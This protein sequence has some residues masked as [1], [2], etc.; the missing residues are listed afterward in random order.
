ML[1]LLLLDPAED[2]VIFWCQQL[3]QQ[4]RVLLLLLAARNSCSCR[5]WWMPLTLLLSLVTGEPVPSLWSLL[6][7]GNTS[8]D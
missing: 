8:G 2:D 1:L 3:E 6:T 5:A 4:S 7:V